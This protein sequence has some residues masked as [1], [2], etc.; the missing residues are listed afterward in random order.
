MEINHIKCKTHADS[1]A[2]WLNYLNRDDELS[3]YRKIESFMCDKCKIHLQESDIIDSRIMDSRY[4]SLRGN[5][6][7]IS[8][9]V[10]RLPDYIRL[11]K[12]KCTLPSCTLDA[13]YH[14]EFRLLDGTLAQPQ[15][16]CV[17]HRMNNE[18]ESYD[19]ICECIWTAN[20]FNPLE[21]SNHDVSVSIECWLISLSKSS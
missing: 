11:G 19:D 20:I 14:A 12:I 7:T 3:G 6:T 9:N 18:Y 2:Q 21:I 4:I 10:V 5:I 13:S 8:D 16:F 1:Q 17:F 15:P